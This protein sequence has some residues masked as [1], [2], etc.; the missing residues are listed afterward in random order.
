VIDTKGRAFRR[1]TTRYR[2]T[3]RPRLLLSQGPN[4]TGAQPGA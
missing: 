1:L 4:S 3:S 2:T